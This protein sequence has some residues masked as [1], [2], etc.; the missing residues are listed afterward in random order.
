V[1]ALDQALDLAEPVVV[2]LTG[3]GARLVVYLL[4]LDGHLADPL[5]LAQLAGARR[6]LLPR[7]EQGVLAP[8]ELLLVELGGGGCPGGLLGEQ[9]RAGHSVPGRLVA[10][11]GHVETGGC[12]ELLLLLLLLLHQELLVL[13]EQLLLLVLG[14]GEDVREGLNLGARE[15]ALLVPRGRVHGELAELL[16]HTLPQQVLLHQLLLL[17]FLL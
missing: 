16:L 15:L 9:G 14:G 6:F 3:S 17:L 7:Q 4:G 12:T 2:I 10:T 1:L 8:T 5:R 11:T 13:H